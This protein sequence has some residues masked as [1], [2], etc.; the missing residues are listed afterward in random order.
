MPQGKNEMKTA[1]HQTHNNLFLLQISTLLKNE[2]SNTTNTT[3]ISFLETIILESKGI[4]TINE[5]TIFCNIWAILSK[6]ILPMEIIVW[7]RN[8]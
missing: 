8:A 1:Q 6:G 4:I 2:V 3:N 5:V 7:Q